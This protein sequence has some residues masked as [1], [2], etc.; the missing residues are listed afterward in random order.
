M[1]WQYQSR[2]CGNTASRRSERVTLH[3]WHETFAAT[4]CLMS[5]GGVSVGSAQRQNKAL[6]DE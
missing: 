1:G 2:A 6:T 4:F 5:L 3:R